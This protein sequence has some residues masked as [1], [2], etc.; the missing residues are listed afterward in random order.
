[1][2][3]TDREY[4]IKTLKEVMEGKTKAQYEKAFYIRTTERAI[5]EIT[6]CKYV[7]DLVNDMIA[8]KE[9]NIEIKN[10]NVKIYHVVDITKE[11]TEKKNE[12]DKQ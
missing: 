10:V 8:K 1:M 4:L 2:I 5:E 3:D 6:G 9:V 12:D 7:D 11:K